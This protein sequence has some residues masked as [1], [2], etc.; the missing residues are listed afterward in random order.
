MLLLTE[1]EPINISIEPSS[2]SVS[3]LESESSDDDLKDSK[4]TRDIGVAK[5]FDHP[6][7]VSLEQLS[8]CT[9]TRLFGVEVEDAVAEMRHRIHLA[10]RLTASA[11]YK[12][13]HF[14]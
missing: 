11:G 8:G 10:T 1:V 12:I 6:L 7:P 14:S 5:T 2:F 3:N 13:L 9:C 4:Q